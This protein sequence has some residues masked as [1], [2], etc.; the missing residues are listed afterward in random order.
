MPDSR[1]KPANAVGEGLSHPFVISFFGN[2]EH[3]FKKTSPKPSSC[4]SPLSQS[5]K[6]SSRYSVI[7][8]ISNFC[9]TT[10]DASNHTKAGEIIGECE[11]LSVSCKIR[12]GSAT[13]P[14]LFGHC[15]IKD[16]KFYST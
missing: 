11:Y 14:R 2:F 13:N 16:L 5:T 7:S 9:T 12:W 4:G 3:K 6:I 8:N 1:E 10:L 15:E